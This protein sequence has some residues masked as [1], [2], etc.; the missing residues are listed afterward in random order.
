V[1]GEPPAP[2]VAEPPTH[3]PATHST[4]RADPLT[5]R[6]VLAAMFRHADLRLTHPSCES[7][8]GD[9][10]VTSFGVAAA[11]LL[12][13]LADAQASGDPAA[14]TVTCDSAS[15]NSDAACA[16]T[17]RVDIDDPWEYGLH[18]ALRPDDT[19]AVESI[20]CPGTG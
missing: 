13:V 7:I 14:L 17:V 8:V 15:T 18:F 9:V 11:H 1:R 5:Q 6:D 3:A 20:T 10:D 4:R 2:S 16:F 19:I 12:A